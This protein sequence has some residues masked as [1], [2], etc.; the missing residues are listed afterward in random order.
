MPNAH[1]TLT[2]RVAFSE[3]DQAG[4]MHFSNFL[5][6]MEDAEHAFFRSLGL[7]IETERDG[8]RISWPRVSV[9]CDFSGPARFQ[10]ELE[11]RLRVARVGRK[12]V[13][14]EGE[15]LLAGR[16][17]ALARSTSVCCAIHPGRD[18]VFEPIDIPD[19]IRARLAQGSCE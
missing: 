17:V 1:H 2:R 7:S 14:F 16:P 19:D 3:T 15:F 11:V 18:G 8:V 5:R 6:W 12:S 10:D 4:V 13:S 9:G